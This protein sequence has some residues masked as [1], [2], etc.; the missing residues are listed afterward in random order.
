MS[1]IVYSTESCPNCEQLK[2][3]LKHLG[4]AFEDRDMGDADSLTDIRC[5][6]CFTMAA[7]VLRVGDKFYAWDKL[8]ISDDPT[9]LSIGK[10]NKILKGGN[11]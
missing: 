9:M 5:G 3:E 2:T 4:A 11:K 10:L 1:I 8:C 6:G 7:P